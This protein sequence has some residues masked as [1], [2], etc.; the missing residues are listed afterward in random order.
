M[1]V[2]GLP[3]V[4]ASS[5][6]HGPV[7]LHSI[8]LVLLRQAGL[9]GVGF[10]VGEETPGGGHLSSQVCRLVGKFESAAVLMLLLEIPQRAVGIKT[11]R[12]G[13]E[14]VVGTLA[15]TLQ[16]PSEL[17]YQVV[18]VSLVPVELGHPSRVHHHIAVP[19]EALVSRRRNHSTSAT[20]HSATGF[21]SSSP[22]EDLWKQIWN[23]S[24]FMR[25]R[26]AAS[27]RC[28]N[29]GGSMTM[30]SGYFAIGSSATQ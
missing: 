21:F 22:S 20:Y 30:A 14:L 4:E 29:P 27:N 5:P 26:H 10:R 6:Q 23:V 25:R 18:L 3:S 19:N 16:G 28:T 13:R 11:G 17:Q 2:F 24:S 12:E 15:S 9:L 8:L 1:Q 7:Q